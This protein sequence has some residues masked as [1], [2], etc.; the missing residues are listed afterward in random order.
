MLSHV[1]RRNVQSSYLSSLLGLQI[2]KDGTL[3]LN[4]HVDFTLRCNAACKDC[5]KLL[6][7]V[8]MRAMDSDLSVKNIIDIAKIFK[9]NQIR[10]R[11]LRISGGEPLLHPL[12]DELLQEIMKWWNPIVIRV[13]T[14]G[15]IPLSKKLDPGY[16][17]IRLSGLEEKKRLHVPFYVSPVDLG[18][19][20]KHGFLDA[21]GMTKGCGRSVNAFG[22]TPCQLYP[23]IGR[24]LGKDVHTARPKLFGDLE[25]CQHCIC[26]LSK[27]EQRSIHEVI[28]NGQ[29][30]YP[31]KTFSEGIKREQESPTAMTS[32]INKMG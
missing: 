18:I 3:F 32:L 20:P 30:K 13:F 12:F 16:G 9:Q 4:F 19:E 26:S 11:R 7:Q 2:W 6:G 8:P 15:I 23:H 5:I 25:I 10:I 31:T 17:T 22:F 1:D 24:L 28:A 29:I 14:N 21:C 27:R